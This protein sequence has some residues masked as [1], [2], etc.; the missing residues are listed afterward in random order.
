V[1]ASSSTLHK[2]LEPSNHLSPFHRPC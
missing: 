2:C 1:L